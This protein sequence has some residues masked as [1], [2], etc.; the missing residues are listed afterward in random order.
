MSLFDIVTKPAETTV[1]Y[2]EEC[3][4]D[5][6]LVMPTQTIEYIPPI[7]LP[8]MSQLIEKANHYDDEV[9]KFYLSK[10]IVYPIYWVKHSV[11]INLS[12]LDML[13]GRSQHAHK[14]EYHNQIASLLEELQK[15]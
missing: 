11:Y 5:G 14:N 12:Y 4:F 1:N 9:A 2:Y 6:N 13:L 15:M 3:K 8:L 7:L 10:T